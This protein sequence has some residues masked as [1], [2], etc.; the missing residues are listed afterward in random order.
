MFRPAFKNY[1]SEDR[2]KTDECSD[3]GDSFVIITDETKNNAPL[4]L[5]IAPRHDSIGLEAKHETQF[6]ATVTARDLPENSDTRAP[7]DII[8]ALDVS[9]S[10]RGRK[11]ELCKETLIL[12]LRELSIQDTFGLVT[13]GSEATIQIPTRKLSKENKKN[14]IGTIKKLATSGRTNLSAGIGLAAQEVQSLESPNEVQTIFLLTD[15]VANRGISHRPRVVQLTKGCLSSS[16]NQAPVSIHCFGYGADHDREMLRDISQATEGGSYYFVEKDSDVSS[17]F[18]DALGGVLSVVAQNTILTFKASNDY[19]IRLISILH[20]RAIKQIDGSFT[21][22]VGDFYAEESRDIIC[23]IVL[24]NGSGFS[25]KPVPHMSVSMTY[26]DTVNRKLAKHEA[27]EGLIS[28]PNGHL[29]S[30]MNNHVALQYIRVTTT[31]IIADAD[32]L[33]AAGNL[34]SAKAKINSH[35]EHLKREHITLG[36]SNPLILQFLIELNQIVSGL[37]SQ[38]SWK[39]G[40]ACYMQGRIQTH[41]KQRCSESSVMMSPMSPYSSSRKAFYSMR[42]SESHNS[43]TADGNLETPAVRKDT[44]TPD[45]NKGVQRFTESRSR[46][47][48][49]PFNPFLTDNNLKMPAVYKDTSRSIQNKGVFSP[50]KKARYSMESSDKSN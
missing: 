49:E 48:S 4:D 14:A 16:N 8:V 32:K 34:I 39:S 28:R 35:I 27:V 33:A 17:A 11:L 36:G 29:V 21:V 44:S 12:L 13:F 37:S 2:S 22:E 26:M 30:Q 40:G 19:G 42:L 3:G 50:S 15:G 24:A 38:A 5:K 1:K 41:S 18:G 6:C 10:M 45:E 47:L 46:I 20:E 7:V 43:F 9:H 23:N 25:S 31:N